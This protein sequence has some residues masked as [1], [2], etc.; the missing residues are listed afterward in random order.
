MGA[1]A[2]GAVSDGFASDGGDQLGWDEEA[3]LQTELKD[4]KELEAF[5][6]AERERQ[7]MALHGEVSEAVLRQLLRE[8]VA[9]LPK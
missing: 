4:V 3:Q 7:R 5:V 9:G 1:S 2:D 8:A 6:G